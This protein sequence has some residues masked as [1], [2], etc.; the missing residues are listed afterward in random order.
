RN[1]DQFEEWK[2]KV[3]SL[4]ECYHLT[5]EKLEQNPECTYCHF[6]PREEFSGKK[7]AISELEEQLDAL[8][9]SLIDILLTNFNDPD[10][11][12]SINLLDGQHKALIE[13]FITNREFQ[14]PIS[15]ELINAINL[16]LKGIHNEVIEIDK[17]ILALGDGNPI[18][19]QQAKTNIEQLLRSEERRV[20]KECR[21]RW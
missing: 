17:I 12:E 5:P 8:L 21:S 18:T 19:V 13:G 20:G 6:N 4:K 2:Q 15:L 11:K 1:N 7:Y 3:Q 14:F 16:V 10:V 9:T